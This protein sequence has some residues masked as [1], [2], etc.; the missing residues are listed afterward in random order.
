MTRSSLK[1]ANGKLNC[2]DNHHST[3]ETMG[4]RAIFGGMQN[5]NKEAEVET[6]VWGWGKA[7]DV[8]PWACAAANTRQGIGSVW[9]WCY[10]VV[11]N[12]EIV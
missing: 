10:S 11:F 8:L 5:V 4:G 1:R 3:L 9:W 12:T 7:S 6:G 2:F